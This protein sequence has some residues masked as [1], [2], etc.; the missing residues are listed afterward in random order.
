MK[1]KTLLVALTTVA[2]A[3][4]AAAIARALVGERLAA[5]VQ[6]MAISSTYAWQ[7]RIHDEG[8]IL[9]VIKA[10]GDV[11]DALR[12]RVLALHP[13][14]VPEFVVLAAADVSDGYLA[15]AAGACGPVAEGS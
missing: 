6:R 7:G 3:E 15:W 10:T 1:K 9:L 2:D 12:D 5:C 8:E 11:C 4:T 13:Y 14:D